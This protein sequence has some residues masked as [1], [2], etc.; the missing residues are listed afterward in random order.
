[1]NDKVAG[2]RR[3]WIVVIGVTNAVSHRTADRALRNA[4]FLQIRPQSRLGNAEVEGIGQQV[5][6][7]LRQV[8]WCGINLSCTF[9]KAD[10]TARLLYR[11]SRKRQ[12]LCIERARRAHR[13]LQKMQKLEKSDFRKR[14]ALR[15]F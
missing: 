4:L 5:D 10:Q 13:T 6:K 3:G 12:L 7:R 9:D 14:R 1:V 11:R 8:G 2:Q 15:R